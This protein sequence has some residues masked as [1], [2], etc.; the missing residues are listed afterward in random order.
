MTTTLFLTSDI[1]QGSLISLVGRVVAFDAEGTGFNPSLG[2]YN[3]DI[4]RS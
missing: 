2:R 4:Y 1:K 3:Y